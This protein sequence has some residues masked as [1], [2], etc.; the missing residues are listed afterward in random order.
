MSTTRKRINSINPNVPFVKHGKNHI[1]GSEKNALGRVTNSLLFSKER[2]KVL[3][4]VHTKG[5]HS[6]KKKKEERAK[7]DI[8]ISLMQK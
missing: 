5:G 3:H 7:N 1:G 6:V 2:R 8:D 4:V